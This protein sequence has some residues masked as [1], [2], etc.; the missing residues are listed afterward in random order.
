MQ[1]RRKTTSRKSKRAAVK[2]VARAKD[3]S[4][5]DLYLHGLAG[6]IGLGILIIPFFIALLYGGPFSIYLVIGAGFIALLLAML[7]Y[8][9]SITH[10]HDPYNFLK[11]TSGKEYSF[12]F[13]FL[14]L[15]SFIITATAAGIASVG[16]LSLFFGISSYTSIAVIDVA[17]LVMWVLFFYNKVKSSLNFAGALKILFVLLLI[18][19]GAVSTF[20]SGSNPSISIPTASLPY[21]PPLFFFGLLLLLWMYGGFEGAAIVYKGE[22]KV[23]VAKSLVYIIITSII[24]FSIVQV[25]AYTTVQNSI[26]KIYTALAA[27]VPTASI[28]T[29]NIIASNTGTIVESILIALS[30]VVILSAAFAVINAANRTLDDMAND[31]L[32][33]KFLA[34]DENLKLLVTA[35]VPIILI[36]VFSTVMISTS[37]FDYIA[38]III[39]ALAFAAAFAFFAA[40]YAVHYVKQKKYS[41]FV[42]G[43]FTVALM[44]LLII[45]SPA[46]FLIGLGIIL[47]VALVGYAL[48]K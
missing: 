37:V 5:V 47:L 4:I 2:P 34:K 18:I 3:H 31:G 38:I 36:T 17:F 30:I 23:K 48:V 12:V 27:N 25:F 8:D 32:M 6:V 39:S 35:A 26:T 16:E 29:T 21:T 28:F 44:I 24:L 40:G 22:N 10:S 41:R 15:V 20:A 42:F 46:A 9:I 1:N 43:L 13:G 11:N 45:S 19:V 33:P 14:L 7:I